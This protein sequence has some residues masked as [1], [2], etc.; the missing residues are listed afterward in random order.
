[1]E[2][3]PRE[4]EIKEQIEKIDQLLANPDLPEEMSGYLKSSKA[5]LDVSLNNT[6]LPRSARRRLIMLAVFILGIMGVIDGDMSWLL[7]LLVPIFS[8]KIVIKTSMLIG[9]MLGNH[10]K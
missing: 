6:W 1:M 9:Y 5:M 7:L 8:P 4:K 2:K 3:E 10:K